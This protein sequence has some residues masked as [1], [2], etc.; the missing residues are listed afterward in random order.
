M[1]NVCFPIWFAPM[2]GPYAANY[3]SGVR[4]AALLVV[5][6]PLELAV[7]CVGCLVPRLE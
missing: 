1:H 4:A 5:S 3:W 2:G 7:S 6:H